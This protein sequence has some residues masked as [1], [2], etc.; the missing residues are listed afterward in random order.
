MTFKSLSFTARA[1]FISKVANTLNK[2][3]LCTPNFGK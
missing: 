1:F 3:Y 2:R